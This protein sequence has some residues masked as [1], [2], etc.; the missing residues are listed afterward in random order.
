[1]TKFY[2]SFSRYLAV[3]LFLITTVA[4]SQSRTVTG[5]VTA[6]DDGTGLPGVNIVEKG[7]NNGTVSDVDGNYSVNVSENATL[8]F[9]FVGYAS[10][11][12][13]VA[14]KTTID[15]SLATDVLSLN[16]VV[17][18][19]YGTQEKKE[20]TGAVVSIDAKNFN[21][22]NI[23]D[24]T[25]LLQG[26]IAGLSVYNK[27][28]DPNTNSTIRLRGISTVGA[29]TSPLI[30][31]DGVLGASLDNI[32]PN[33]IESVNVLKDGSA[34][35]IYG[36]RGSSGVIL[37]T[38]KRGSKGGIGVSYNGYV[39]AASVFKQIP[40]MSAQEYVAAG[41]NDLGSRTDWQK[42]V[43]QTG[44]SNV[45]NIA[46]S[47]GGEHT[48]FRI[49]TNI[50]NI[51][52]VLKKSGFDQINSRA[53]LTHSALDGRLK[54]DMSMSLTNRNFDRSFN[55]ALRYATL[56]NPTAP[57]YFP[58]GDYYQAILFDNF[59]PVAILNQNT[60][61][62]TRRTINYGA[63]VDYTIVK[64]LTLT[65]NFAQ[66][67]QNELTNEYYSINSLFR[68][69]NRHGLARKNTSDNS[70]T[71][72]EGYATYSKGFDRLNV[73]VT[74]GYSYQQD[75]SQ[76][77]FVELGN[78]PSD[79]LG[80]N[81]LETSGDRI[82]G[83]AARTNISSDRSPVNKIIA[84]FG[85]VNFTFDNA[86]FLNA[87]IRREGSTK[88]GKN[89]QW[90]MFP[91]VGLG[92]DLNKYLQIGQVSLLKLRAGYGVTGSL[93][94]L[95]GYAQAEWTYGFAGGGAVTK[96]R[97]ANPD[98]KWEEKGELN[99]GLDFGLFAGKL[100]G[101]VDVYRRTI[102]DFIL[103]YTP[104]AG[105]AATN[106]YYRN[107]GSLRTNGFEINLNYNSLQFGD[108]H[109]TPGLVLSHYKSKLTEYIINEFMIAELGAPGQNG[110]NMVR[111]AVGE[112]IGQIWGP[113]FDGVE[114]NGAP[115]FKDLNGDGVV[116][117]AQ[118]E[119][120]SDKGDFKKLGSGL[121]TMEL[122]FTNSMT[123]KSWDMS[124]L[125]RGAFGHSLVNNFRA[126]YE[127][128]DPGAI[129]SYNRVTT[130]KAVP[131]LTS[132]QYSSLYVEKADFVKLD[133]ISIGYNFKLKGAVKSLRLY[134][135]G[136]N[137]FQITNYTGIDP[138]P[139]LQDSPS[140]DNGGFFD[141]NSANAR[142]QNTVLAP[143]ID[144]RNN[145]FT[146][147]TFTFG[148]NFGL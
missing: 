81:A 61:E 9:S 26:K 75:Q 66:Q 55:E 48:S 8:V 143:G 13:T 142:P 144:R 47:G 148:L 36:S 64:N 98:L 29:N 94:P 12:Q 114:G 124:F 3:L 111:V 59:N 138:E 121:P 123:Y 139:V 99:V 38:T 141:P 67:N 117:S 76:S 112:D 74:G 14:G 108:L 106:P 23:N 46:I 115:R 1:M 58:N 63:K 40:I 54:V 110:T 137:L 28:G 89:N 118:A 83:L 60:N 87:S 127:P 133:N 68:G 62:G 88:L 43:T 19:G 6:S 132:A 49:S 25:Q 2:L 10:Q 30:V 109:W 84:M 107:V 16:E 65:A 21:K 122:G 147:K 24:P 120:L 103:L 134:V 125:L 97:E 72:F 5:K 93:P 22:G 119:A 53:S 145:Y 104:Q 82:S 100:N 20:I 11:E 146:A 140:L 42:L 130:N 34:A 7:T 116:T 95:P 80:Y 70:F 35:A 79:Q 33:D 73:D 85:R 102:S 131:G 136:Q 18:V 128:I 17:V 92:V 78:F 77:M 44:V 57:V 90:G 91:S 135:T 39:S 126:F 31:I 50:R 101:S 96:T 71:L 4:W 86:I 32:D 41:G 15:V 52:G 27:G 51:N 105:E 129:N 113:V 37:I 69:Y 45:H 56:Y